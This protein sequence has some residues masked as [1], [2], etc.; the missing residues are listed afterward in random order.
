MD[1]SYNNPSGSQ[2][3]GLTTR[4]P[5]KSWSACRSSVNRYRQEHD[6]AATT[7]SA[8][9]NDTR[10]GFVAMRQPPLAALSRFCIRPRDLLHARVIIAAGLLSPE[11]L[12][13]CSAM[14]SGTGRPTRRVNPSASHRRLTPSPSVILQFPEVC[15]NMAP[16]SQAR[17]SAAGLGRIC[18]QSRR[19]TTT[20]ERADVWLGAA[21]GFAGGGAPPACPPKH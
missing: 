4:T 11:P 9:Q 20:N 3:N 2:L 7:I 13:V 10:D 17:H 15:K 16:E 12:V 19:G 1:D 18:P 8:S 5:P 14:Y 21:T 6:F